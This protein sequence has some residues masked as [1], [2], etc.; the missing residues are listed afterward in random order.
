MLVQSFRVA[1]VSMRGLRSA[2]IGVSVAFLGVGTSHLHLQWSG[3]DLSC[4]NMEMQ[5]YAARRAG[6]GQDL[7]M[8]YEQPDMPG[9]ELFRRDRTWEVNSSNVGTVANAA[10]RCS[11]ASVLPG[12]C[13]IAQ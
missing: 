4:Q 1:S 10:R 13:R 7:I 3:M 5:S 8:L 2:M 9:A 6:S 12:F 11:W